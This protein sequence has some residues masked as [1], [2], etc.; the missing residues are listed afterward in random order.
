MIVNG[1]FEGHAANAVGRLGR[2]RVQ[3]LILILNHVVI[4]FVQIVRLRAFQHILL[5]KLLVDVKTPLVIYGLVFELLVKKVLVDGGAT[6]LNDGL[7]TKIVNGCAARKLLLK[8]RPLHVW[9]W[10]A[11]VKFVLGQRLQRNEHLIMLI[12]NFIY[13]FQTFGHALIFILFFFFD[14][15]R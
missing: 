10:P 8:E 6:L 2:L 7:T 13:D 5:N 15:S 12:F 9:R 11:P 4:L 1:L 14:F 3:N